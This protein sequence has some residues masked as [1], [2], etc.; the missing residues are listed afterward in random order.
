MTRKA[1]AKDL[2]SV[3]TALNEEDAQLALTDFNDMCG[4][5]YPN[6]TVSW[7]NNWAELSTFFKY[8]ETVRKLIYTT[9]LANAVLQKQKV[10][11]KSYKI[12]KC[13]YKKKD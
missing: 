2:K 8:P 10:S 11:L 4:Y 5:K 1:V 9:K 6:I 13:Y 7:A 3:Y 12:F